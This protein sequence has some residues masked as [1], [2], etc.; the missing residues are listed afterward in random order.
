[1]LHAPASSV[2]H[3]LGAK[4][5]LVSSSLLV[6]HN[7]QN[8]NLLIIG[9]ASLSGSIVSHALRAGASIVLVTPAAHVS[10]DLKALAA[11]G[12]LAWFNRSFR[13]SDLDGKHMVF[14]ELT[15]EQAKQGESA[16]K[17]ASL[18]RSRNILVSVSDPSIESDFELVPQTAVP[19]S[20][21][22]SDSDSDTATAIGASRSP[23]KLSGRLQRQVSGTLPSKT[24]SAIERITQLSQA[25]LDATTRSHSLSLRAQFVDHIAETWSIAAI[26]DL[27]SVAIARLVEQFKAGITEPSPADAAPA[28]GSIAFVTVA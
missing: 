4:P 16:A 5:E 15:S 18:C 21:V 17:I 3:T 22:L 1:M 9:G 10:P 13:E 11:E 14:V 23:I 6:S 27:D 28:A 19:Q 26:S 25:L 8:R 12:E 2:P 7:L 24:G 20:P